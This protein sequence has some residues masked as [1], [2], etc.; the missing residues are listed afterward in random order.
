M[1]SWD[2]ARIIR[3]VPAGALAM[4]YYFNRE[5]IFLAGGIIPGL[6]ATLNINCPGGSCNTNISKE[7]KTEIKIKKYEPDK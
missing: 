4:A 1:N 2:T 3:M 7:S 6:Q 5:T